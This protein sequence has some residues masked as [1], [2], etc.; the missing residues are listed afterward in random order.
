MEENGIRKRLVRAQT[1][2]WLLGAVIILYLI[3]PNTIEVTSIQW[4]NESKINTLWSK[5][6]QLALAI[7]T[8]IAV[9]LLVTERFREITNKQFRQDVLESVKNVQERSIEAAYGK[10]VEPEV[11]EALERSVFAQDTVRRDANIT[12]KF[13][14]ENG[15]FEE[16][17][18]WRDKIHNLTNNIQ[19]YKYEVITS[20]EEQRVVQTKMVPRT[21]GERHQDESEITYQDLLSMRE[22]EFEIPVGG[23]LDLTRMFKVYYGLKDGFYHNTIGFRETTV[24]LTLEVEK[25]KGFSFEVIIYGGSEFDAYPE[26][27]TVEKRNLIYDCNDA[28]LPGTAV[29]YFLEKQI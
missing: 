28:F 19:N 12:L 16:T 24:G 13:D 25:P 4:I 11:F 14:L 8:S 22:A 2:L 1:L 29:E 26:G 23:R 20:E 15:N 9:A 18:T 10:M 3:V 6:D 7:I 27:G 17:I 5:V 21:E